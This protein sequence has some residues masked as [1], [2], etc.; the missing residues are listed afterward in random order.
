MKKE[1]LFNCEFLSTYAYSFKRVE[2]IKSYVTFALVISR[3]EGQAA[4]AAPK[5]LWPQLAASA[6]AASAVGAR[7]RQRAA[8]L[9]PLRSL[10]IVSLGDGAV[11]FHE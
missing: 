2:N 11:M 6:A 4:A 7:A 1:I 5:E 3:R 10:I 9:L 8:P